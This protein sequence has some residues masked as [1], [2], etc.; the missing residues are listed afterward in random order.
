MSQV[1]EVD[2]VVKSG[3]GMHVEISSS[4]WDSTGHKRK[5]VER[6]IKGDD[7]QMLKS[8]YSYQWCLCGE[9]TEMVVG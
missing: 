5:L 7:R 9:C 3:P 6:L 1:H 2:A 4:A 8:N